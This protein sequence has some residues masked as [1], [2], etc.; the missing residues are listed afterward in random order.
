MS[1]VEVFWNTMSGW[2]VPKKSAVS[3]I[4]HCVP[5]MPSETLE[6]M[7]GPLISQIRR[8][9]VDV[10]VHRISGEPSPLKSP[11]AEIDQPA[12]AVATGTVE[13]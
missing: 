11:T 10:L 6:T 9:P 3:A 7:L 2:P 1:P 13:T 12:G 8:S 4:R 5:T